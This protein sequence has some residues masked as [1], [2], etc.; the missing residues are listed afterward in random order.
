M[1]AVLLQLAGEILIFA[2]GDAAFERT[3]RR[4][5]RSSDRRALADGRIR[6]I[7]RSP[8]GRVQDVGPEWSN[9]MAHLS[10]GGF[11]FVPRT[12]IVGDR[13]IAV[14]GVEHH[15]HEGEFR[16]Y[17][18]AVGTGELL[19]GIPSEVADEVLDVVAPTRTAR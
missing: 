16:V 5:A 8:V 4:L 6:S 18:V 11:R 2:F 7:L 3:R 1:L 14:L 9:G 15:E 10:Q 17:R 19:W 13:E 12:G